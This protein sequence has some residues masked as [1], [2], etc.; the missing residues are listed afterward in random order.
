MNEREGFID[1][2]DQVLDEHALAGIEKRTGKVARAQ[3]DLET[4][5][6]KER[7]AVLGVDQL[8][9][10]QFQKTLAERPGGGLELQPD[11]G[12]AL[13]ALFEQPIEAVDAQRGV[14]KKR[15]QERDDE[16]EDRK[17]SNGRPEEHASPATLAG[18]RRHLAGVVGRGH[19]LAVCF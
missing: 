1:L 16:Q 2:G 5:E 7:F 6:A 19:L 18:A 17:D 4:P 9:T 12:F 3:V 13:E 10:A 14:I 15:E 11:A 8:R